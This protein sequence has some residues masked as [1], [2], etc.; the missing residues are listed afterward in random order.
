MVEIH[1]KILPF[2]KWA[3]VT[4]IAF[5]FC[6]GFGITDFAMNQ[7]ELPACEA[8]GS[9]PEGVTKCRTTEETSK[10]TEETSE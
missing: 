7:P 6:I 8:D 10:T 5:V 4:G 1:T 2:K 9:V 3:L